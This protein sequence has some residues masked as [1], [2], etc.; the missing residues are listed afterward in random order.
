MEKYHKEFDKYSAFN[1]GVYNGVMGG[2]G[3][4]GQEVLPY[5]QYRLGRVNPSKVSEVN[6]SKTVE[7]N[8]FDPTENTLQLIHLNT[9]NGHF[10]LWFNAE[11]NRFDWMMENPTLVNDL[12]LSAPGT[13]EFGT[14]ITLAS[15]S[16]N[17]DE[18]VIIIPNDYSFSTPNN[19]HSL[20]TDK[21][22]FTDGTYTID[23]VE[24]TVSTKSPKAKTIQFVFK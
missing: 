11:N 10:W 8:G 6:G 15:V 9:K 24:L 21:S 20:K 13:P 17:E 18:T 23:N 19:L 7:L 22:L 12:K 14:G 4:V 5:F 3:E 16:T 2:K 1:Y